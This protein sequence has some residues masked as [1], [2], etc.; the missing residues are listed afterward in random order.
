MFDN[1]LEA[2]SRIKK[3]IFQIALT[4]LLI[5][6][7][8]G[9]LTVSSGFSDFYFHRWYTPLSTFL[10]RAL[11]LIP[12]SIGDVIYI[13]WVI[14]S[15]IF[16]S[17]LIYTAIKRKWKLL[18]F[19][20]LK[21]INALLTIY[22]VF[23]LFWGV[24][25]QRKTLADD[26]ELNVP[27][28]YVRADLYLLSDTLLKLVNRDCDAVRHMPAL[29]D[30]QLFHMATAGYA[31]AKEQWPALLYKNQSVKATLFGR[32][33]NYI[34]VT[35][36]LNPFTN[37][38]QVNTTVPAFVQPF[39]TCHEIAHQLGYAPE[40]DANFVGYLVASGAN[41]VRFRYAANFEMFLYS[42]RHLARRDPSLTRLIWQKA[43]PLVREDY[44]RLMEFY[45][46]FQGP[47]DDYSAAV[48]DQY[49]KANHQ[50]KGIRSYSEVVGWLIAYFRKN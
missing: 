26:I 17:K 39:T 49:L 21:G 47:I 35:G 8:K 30:K 20:F 40:E 42:I 43:N 12:F 6:L 15:I 32:W 18:L 16:F 48:Y 37:E 28:K 10:R 27:E 19:Q 46:Q 7:I 31:R 36:Y 5:V 25:Y 2:G 22:F 1:D 3:K 14:A 13:T 29:S 44:Y 34:G 23:L 41:D 45:D 50:E 11:G 38:A 33:M 24:N 9:M 4:V